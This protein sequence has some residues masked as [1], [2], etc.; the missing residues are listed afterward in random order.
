MFLLCCKMIPSSE[1]NLIK[2]KMGRNKV[3]YSV[4]STVLIKIIY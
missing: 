3:K 2:E 1:H 4:S